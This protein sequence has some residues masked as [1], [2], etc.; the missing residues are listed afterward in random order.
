MKTTKKIVI[1]LAAVLLVLAPTVITVFAQ[2]ISMGMGIGKEKESARSIVEPVLMGHGFAINPL[3]ESQ[4]HILDVTAIKTVNVSSSSIRSLLSENKTRATDIKNYIQNAPSKAKGDL[5]FAG[6]A[7][8]LDITSYDN[9]SLNGNVMT[10][11]PGGTN[12]STFTPTTVGSISLSMSNYEGAVVST[13]TLTMN[14][15][16]YNVLQTSPE[17]ASISG[18]HWFDAM[19]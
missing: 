12:Y 19:Q 14:G 18:H 11:P 16:L 3:N 2:P 6:Q 10:L 4:Y 13:G 17:L 5:M 15:T 1:L 7:Y 9:R 8:A